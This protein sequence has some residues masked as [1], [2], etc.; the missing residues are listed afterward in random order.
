M[1][2]SQELS[3]EFVFLF[4]YSLAPLPTP[5]LYPTLLG[6]TVGASAP[7]MVLLGG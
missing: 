4:Y 6:L 7:N 5:C 3:E 2:L 1:M